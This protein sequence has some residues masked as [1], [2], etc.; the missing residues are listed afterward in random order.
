[1]IF[2]NYWKKCGKIKKL[3]KLVIIWLGVK[4][5]DLCFKKNPL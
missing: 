2:D 1:M 5:T 3:N 4:I